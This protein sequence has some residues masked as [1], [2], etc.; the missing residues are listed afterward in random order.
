[1]SRLFFVEKGQTEH[2]PISPTSLHSS[3]HID[4]YTII[5]KAVFWFIPKDHSTHLQTWPTCYNNYMKKYDYNCYH[6]TAAGSRVKVVL[7]MNALMTVMTN[8]MQVNVNES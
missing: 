8:Y 4:L 5:S 7:V 6:P 3:K 2:W 1:M